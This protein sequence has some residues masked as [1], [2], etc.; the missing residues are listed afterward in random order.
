MNTEL[1]FP[2]YRTITGSGSTA[3]YEVIGWIGFVVE[4]VT[5]GG[6][7]ATLHGYFTRVVWEASPTTA[8]AVDYGVRAIEL[9][10]EP[11]QEGRGTSR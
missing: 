1:L 5:G 2:I 3:D 8:P 9:I 6:S 7:N 4:D 10:D 11:R